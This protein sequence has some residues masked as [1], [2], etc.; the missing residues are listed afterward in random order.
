MTYC[1]RN[2]RG[3]WVGWF[4]FFKY[5]K[6]HH[7]PGAVSVADCCWHRLTV[8]S[9]SIETPTCQATRCAPSHFNVFRGGCT[10]QLT[11]PPA[12]GRESD[13]WFCCWWWRRCSDSIAAPGLTI[14]SPLRVGC[15]V[16]NFMVDSPLR[17]SHARC[18]LTCC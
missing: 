10:V 5:N 16:E 2:Q 17:S 1:P 15:L 4:F 9:F 3:G 11:L 13:K 7:R 18:R 6:S 8:K 12:F 14:S